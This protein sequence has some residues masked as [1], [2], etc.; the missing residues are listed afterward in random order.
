MIITLAVS[1]EGAPIDWW[2]V[3][4]GP[5]HWWSVGSKLFTLVVNEK[6]VPYDRWSVQRMRL[7]LVV[8]AKNTLKLVIWKTSPY[9]GGQLEYSLH[10]WSARR[11]LLILVVDGRNAPYI[12]G[13]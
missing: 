2:L 11:M 6:N 1:R 12:G 9:I 10:W 8:S 13:Q 7:T 3:E 5:L 4:K